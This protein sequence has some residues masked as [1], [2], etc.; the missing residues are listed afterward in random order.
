MATQC[1]VTGVTIWLSCGSGIPIVPSQSW[2]LSNEDE[3]AA[4]V[5]R[6]HRTRG[7]EQVHTV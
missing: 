5:M 4:N 6:P 7:E 1:R 2:T 3:D